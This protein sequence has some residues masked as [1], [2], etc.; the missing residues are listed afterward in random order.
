M[1]LLKLL[2]PFV[3]SILLT[4]CSNVPEKDKITLKGEWK[5]RID[6][7]DIGIKNQWYRENFSQ[8]LKLPGSL[9]EQG[10]GNNIDSSTSWT[11]SIKGDFFQNP[12]YKEYRQKEDFKVPFWLNPKK[13]YKGA[14]W[15]QKQVTVP[16]NWEDLRVTL[17]LER[18]HWET[19]VY[20]D[21]S[22]AGVQNSLSTPHEYDL[23]DYLTPGNNKITI[24]VDNRLVINVGENS[25]SV[26]DHTQSN[27]N[28]IAGDLLMKAQPKVYIEDIQIYPDIHKDQAAV[29]VQLRNESGTLYEG[30]MTLQAQ[31]KQAEW[32][33]VL[34]KKSQDIRIED[35]KTVKINYPMGED[36]QL[37]SEFDP[38]L[39]S[40][41]VQLEEKN[42]EKP[43]DVD[44]VTFGMREFGT[45]DTRFVIN[46]RPVFLRGTLECA[47]FPK[48]GYPATD[49]AEWGRIFRKIK[50]YGLNHMR[51]HSWCPPEEAFTAADKEGV[52]LQVECASWANQGA[53]LGSGL[54][55][56][57]WIYKESRR[58][59]EEYGNHP[60][61]CM[62]AYGNEPAGENQQEYLTRFLEYWKNKDSR[63]VYTSAS[64]WPLIEANQFHVAPQP[65]IQG[66]GQELNSVI[67]REQP[68]TTF[69]HENFVSKYDVPVIGHEI[70][71]WCVYPDFDE[72]KKYTGVLKPKNFEIFR[73]MLKD[74][75]MLDK[76]EKFHMASG[77]LQALCY[78]ADIEAALRT[79]DFAGFQLLDL[80]DFPG[81]GTALVGVAD[82]FWDSKDYISP[83]KYKRFAGETVPLARMPKRVYRNSETFEATLELAHF[84]QS[85][86]IN[87]T[88]NWKIE[89][90]NGNILKEDEIPDN[91][92]PYDNCTKIGDIKYDLSK[93]E[94]PQKLTL[95][96]TFSRFGTNSWDF[97][98]YPAQLDIPDSDDIIVAS[99]LT[100]QVRQSLS[101][102]KKVLLILHDKIKGDKGG[103]VKV[104][105]SPI[106]WN[107]MWTDNQAPHTMGVL[108]EP[109]H[110]LF[111]DF[112]TEYH[113]NWQWWDIVT[114][115]QVMNMED[116]TKQ[117]D[118]LIQSIPD[119][120]KN[121]KLAFAFEGNVGN[122]KL[123][124]T[125]I[126]F[127]KDLEENLASRQLYY[128]MLNY[129]KSEQFA[130]ANAI[131]LENI[132]KLTN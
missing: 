43:T 114:G 52:Y 70:G 15:Y 31:T 98:V 99:E 48:T 101:Q 7:S 123:L 34:E 76:A 96:A 72:M 132:E 60:S 87:I 56:D 16:E 127:T 80:H 94:K 44:S 33:R 90:A 117:I 39:Y 67:N 53:E 121:R 54:P 47:I 24:R 50:Q 120:H 113:S 10:Y 78:K 36:P 126:D 83:E 25:H 92:I 46:H 86:L 82:P 19:T 111:R 73:D 32:K 63:R 5:I 84:G 102:G 59:V 45:E 122:G 11:G 85:A 8:T 74:N 30:K 128:S 68:H 124:V 79:P 29:E 38:N 13:H 42:R 93:L 89:D 112:P 71:Q 21:D 75:H 49:T 118:P 55:V 20:V 37:W 97:W 131:S 62:M 6:T 66:W 129:M 51:F 61:F 125:S 69:N 107:T 4:Y 91:N 108:C 115:A 9:Q 58:I 27:W 81:Q 116:F 110:A 103:N 17:F 104:G 3:L 28:G 88:M 2:L 22:K 119:Y 40:M 100:P 95:T 18:P 41:H 109:E 1:R 105:F 65:R 77:K 26:T 106:F 35:Q 23:T 130:P 64:G 14:A 57:D 12:M